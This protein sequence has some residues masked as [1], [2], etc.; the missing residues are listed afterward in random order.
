MEKMVYVVRNH[1]DLLVEKLQQEGFEVG[2]KSYNVIAM[3]YQMLSPDA[4]G[5]LASFSYEMSGNGIHIAGGFSGTTEIRKHASG[6]QSDSFDAK[7]AAAY[8]ETD[9]VKRNELL[10]EAEE[11]LLAEMP[12]IPILFNRSA[13]LVD[14]DLNRVYYNYYGY[15]VFTR[16]ELRNYHKHLI[17]EE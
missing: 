7:I 10:H 6:F 14:A 1:G 5:A 17:T 11:L 8:A 3:D 9:M 2:G 15:A 13:A 16:T 4:F 12:V